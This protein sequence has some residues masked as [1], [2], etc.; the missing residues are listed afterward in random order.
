MEYKHQEINYEKQSFIISGKNK[1][2]NR[3]FKIDYQIGRRKENRLNKGH[4]T[5]SLNIQK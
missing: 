3:Y 2:V 4:I 5:F 1:Y